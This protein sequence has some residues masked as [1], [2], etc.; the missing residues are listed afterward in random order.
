MS[1]PAE[2]G[3]VA[4]VKR[5]ART[6]EPDPP[7]AGPSWRAARHHITPAQSPGRSG[8]PLPVPWPGPDLASSVASA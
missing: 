7:V 3:L 6:C 5:I 4:V 2:A 8:F 1:K